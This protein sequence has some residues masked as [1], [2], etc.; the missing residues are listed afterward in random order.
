MELRSNGFNLKKMYSLLQLLK[1]PCFQ[2]IPYVSSIRSILF[3]FEVLFDAVYSGSLG[4][5]PLYT[6]NSL[7]S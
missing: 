7:F 1:I 5:T 2:L 3:C 6:Y 4:L